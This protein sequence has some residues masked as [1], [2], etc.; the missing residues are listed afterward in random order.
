M[1]LPIA[2]TVAAGVLPFFDNRQT[3]LLGREYRSFLNTYTWM[4][5]GGKREGDEN[6]AETACREGNEETAGTL[7]ITLEQVLDAEA[8]GNY[9]DFLNPKSSVFYRMYCLDFPTKPDPEL[10][11]TNAALAAHVGMVEWRYFA[12]ADILSNQGGTIPGSE[13]KVYD[14]TCAR[15]DLYRAKFLP[16]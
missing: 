4:E 2:K 15:L 7:N 1:S 14:T 9:I 5:F 10:F 11:T 3:V 6:L 12:A 16:S 13:F 8:L